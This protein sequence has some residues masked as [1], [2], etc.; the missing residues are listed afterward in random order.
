MNTLI[1]FLKNPI[2]G[3]VKTRLARTLGDKAALNVYEQLI[4]ITRKQVNPLNI[5]IRLYFDSIPD[6]ISSP[7]GNQVS[8]HLQTGENLGIK[9]CRAFSETFSGGAEKTVIIGSDCPDLKTEHIQE[10][11]SAL[12]RS[13][14]VVGPAADGGYYLLG[15]KSHFPEVFYGIPW[16]TDLVFELTLEKLQ[17]SRKNVRILPELNDIDEA[18][19]LEPYLRSGKLYL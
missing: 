16:S 5:P 14:A 11:F 19:D 10:A 3:R 9:M 7:W 13:D 2:S 15:M 1:L 17:L 8:F 4:E 6:S 12:D 18:S